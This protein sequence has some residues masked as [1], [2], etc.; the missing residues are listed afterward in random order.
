VDISSLEQ[1]T[2][3]LLQDI[4]RDLEAAAEKADIQ[5]QVACQENSSGQVVGAS[6]KQLE[7]GGSDLLTTEKPDPLI[8]DISE[9]LLLHHNYSAKPQEKS[10]KINRARTSTNKV[11][12]IKKPKEI[13]PKVV[14]TNTEIDTNKLASY[15]DV[16]ETEQADVV[17]GT[18]D[19]STN[20]ITII[21]DD[22]VCLNNV[23]DGEVILE[24]DNRLTVPE[25]EVRSSSPHSSSSSDYGYESLGSPESFAEADD[26]WDNSASELFPALL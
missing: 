3:S 4:A 6:P 5:E 23:T 16:A 20:C 19:E 11:G 7:S 2:Q 22:G 1:L 9:Y 13:L 17:F 15:V 18:Y 10:H 25:C 24:D 26:V 14:A 21:V 8:K 12:K